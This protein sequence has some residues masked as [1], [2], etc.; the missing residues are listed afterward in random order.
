MD[1]TFKLR[2][3]GQDREAVKLDWL[4]ERWENIK[5]NVPLRDKFEKVLTE[6]IRATKS[7]IGNRALSMNLFAELQG[8]ALGKL[9]TKAATHGSGV[10]DSMYSTVDIMF[11]TIR[12]VDDGQFIGYNDLANPVNTLSITEAIQVGLRKAQG[13][14]TTQQKIRAD[15]PE[16]FREIEA[17]V[18]RS[19]RMGKLEVDLP[20][21]PKQ[22]IEDANYF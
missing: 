14:R 6:Q 1:T 13:I 12:L 16:Y 21:L 2:Q 3:R 15:Y 5:D 17:G 11:E 22:A 20:N 8:T 18:I 9:F 4:S 10:V 7:Q 19:K